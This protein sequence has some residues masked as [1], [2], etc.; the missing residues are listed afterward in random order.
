MFKTEELVSQALRHS[1]SFLPQP[2]FPDSISH[3]SQDLFLQAS[4]F[5]G[6][7]NTFAQFVFSSLPLIVFQ[8]QTPLSNTFK[9]LA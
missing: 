3:F 6:G 9:N 1:F 8:V 2:P 4:S 7:K 5:P